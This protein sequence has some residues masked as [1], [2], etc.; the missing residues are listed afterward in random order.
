MGGLPAARQ[1]V[2]ANNWWGS[3][4]MRFCALAASDSTAWCWR[5]DSVPE[6]VVG[7]PAFAA[8]WV[9]NG[10]TFGAAPVRYK[11]YR[12]CGITADSTA[13]CWGVGQPGNGSLWGGLDSVVAV[14]GGGRWVE[15]T[16]GDRFSCGRLP[17]GEVDCWGGPDLTP[18]TPTAVGSG[19]TLLGGSQA[20]VLTALSP[21]Q[22]QHWWAPT[23]PMLLPPT[24]LPNAG[25]LSMAYNTV[26]C[27]RMAGNEVYCSDE[28]DGGSTIVGE[29]A[30]Y[31]VQPVRSET[32]TARTTMMSTRGLP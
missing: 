18:T 2:G 32:L 30:Y 9:A 22:F 14:T 8:I 17:T 16:V 10:N 29:L 12:G 19:A 6:P 21:G 27:L 28:L 1:L 24:G 11:D 4:R 26:T 7:S 13:Y 3:G 5:T 15:L 20:R 23:A 25:V 31:P